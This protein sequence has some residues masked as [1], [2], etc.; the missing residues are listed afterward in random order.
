[1]EFRGIDDVRSDN[2]KSN[3][4]TFPKY[5]FSSVFWHYEV[6]LNLN[7]DIYEE[8]R[9]RNRTVEEFREKPE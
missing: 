8:D 1:M 9:F 3:S 2:R 6:S 7:A 4:L 5:D